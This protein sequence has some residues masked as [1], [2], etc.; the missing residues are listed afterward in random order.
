MFVVIYI[1]MYVYTYMY[2]A[3]NML[4]EEG[5]ALFYSGLGPSLT[6]IVP[7]IAVNFCIFNLWGYT[8]HFPSSILK[9]T[10]RHN[11]Y[12]MLFLCNY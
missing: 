2:V 1:C 8:F 12:D 11:P 3:L 9:N 4:R 10:L 6:G 5:I 7:Y